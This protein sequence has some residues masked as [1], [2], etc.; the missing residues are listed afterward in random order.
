MAN[1]KETGVTT[2]WM[3]SGIDTGDI[4]LMESLPIN[5][6]DTAGTLTPRLAAQGATLLI[7]TLNHLTEGTLPRTPQDHSLATHAPMLVPEDGTILWTETAESVSARIR[8]VNPKPGAQTE[9]Q[10]KRI[11]VWMALPTE[12][13]EADV[14]PGTLLGFQKSPAGLR[15]SA[16]GQSVVLLTEVQPE[17]GKRMNAGD[18]ARGLRLTPGIAFKK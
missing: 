7:N 8:G 18:W 6:E 10:G 9:I 3:D 12:E 13:H 15:V 4:L 5:I 16:G 11:K 2:M 17:S 14:P 1:E